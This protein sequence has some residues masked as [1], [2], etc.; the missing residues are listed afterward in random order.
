MYAIYIH[1]LRS[2][3]VQTV[4]VM[5]K[6]KIDINLSFKTAS[7]TYFMINYLIINIFIIDKIRLFFLFDY[8]WQNILTI[9]PIIQKKLN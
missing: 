2:Y 6:L 8:L 3:F 5:K 4:T 9:A 7:K 1:K